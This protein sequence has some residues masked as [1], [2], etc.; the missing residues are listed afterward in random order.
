MRWD[1]LSFPNPPPCCLSTRRK[2]TGSLTKG[3]EHPRAGQV[4]LASDRELCSSPP[5]TAHTPSSPHADP[6]GCECETAQPFK[7]IRA[8]KGQSLRE[9]Q[10]PHLLLWTSCMSVKRPCVS[11]V[12]VGTYQILWSG[13]RDYTVSIK[14]S[15]QPWLY[16][17][18]EP[19]HSLLGVWRVPCALLNG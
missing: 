10:G 6:S 7:G 3:P 17:R 18:F 9:R 19:D 16:W 14:V 12:G 11:R 13:G 1:L 8:V 2:I 4:A 5:C 15:H